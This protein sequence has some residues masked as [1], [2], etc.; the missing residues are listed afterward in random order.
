MAQIQKGEKKCVHENSEQGGRRR[1][2]VSEQEKRVYE[3]LGAALSSM[4]LDMS[5]AGNGMEALRFFLESSFD[6]ALTDLQMLPTD[7]SIVAHFIKGK[8]P[9]PPVI[10]VPGAD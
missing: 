1:V 2:R 4:G 3:T 7:G 9:N 8:P 10:L 5:L 6:L